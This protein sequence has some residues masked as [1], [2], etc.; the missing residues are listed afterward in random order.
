M[1]GAEMVRAAV[2]TNGQ[3]SRTCHYSGDSRCAY[4]ALRFHHA[5]CKR[6]PLAETPTC[7]VEDRYFLTGGA[8][9][10]VK[11]LLQLRCEMEQKGGRRRE[12]SRY[13]M[14]NSLRLFNR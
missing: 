7:P 2:G 10:R 12:E 9:W 8:S 5:K 13:G 11:R 3:V 4:C 6:C 14:D 1:Y